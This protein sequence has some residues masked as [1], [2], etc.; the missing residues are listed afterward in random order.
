MGQLSV[1]EVWLTIFYI[2]VAIV[3]ILVHVLNVISFHNLHG[4]QMILGFLTDIKT[5]AYFE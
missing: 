1:W 3:K 2:G 5:L 4:N